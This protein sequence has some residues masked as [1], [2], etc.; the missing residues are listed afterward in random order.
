MYTPADIRRICDEYGKL[1][2]GSHVHTSVPLIWIYKGDLGI[3]A[4]YCCNY[5]EPKSVDMFY[6]L[7][8]NGKWDFGGNSY[9]EELTLEEFCDYSSW[10]IGSHISRKYRTT[11]IIYRKIKRRISMIEKKIDEYKLM[12][13]T[14]NKYFI[15]GISDIILGYAL[16]ISVE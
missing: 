1:V 7:H 4:S 6:Y 10:D 3:S 16:L 13:S 8:R 12:Q 9:D 5:Y 14:L 11:N 15:K 2:G